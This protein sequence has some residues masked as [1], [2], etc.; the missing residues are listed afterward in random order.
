MKDTPAEVDARYQAMLMKR[1]G[2][3]RVRMAA[4]MYDAAVAMIEASLSPA[5]DRRERR[6]E[7]FRRLYAA[8]FDAAEMERILSAL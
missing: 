7:R 8:E 1:S 4:E 6:R 3:D 2:S 5:R